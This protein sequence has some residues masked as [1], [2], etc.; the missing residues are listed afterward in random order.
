LTTGTVPTGRLRARFDCLRAGCYN[1]RLPGGQGLRAAVA[2][3]T[4]PGYVYARMLYDHQ[5]DPY[6]NVNVAELP[7]NAELVRRLSGMLAAGWRQALP[8][9]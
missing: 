7:A 9:A 3:S 1:P 5:A 4:E 6:E 2:G 8:G